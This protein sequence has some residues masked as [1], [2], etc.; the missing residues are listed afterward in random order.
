MA[1]V[2]KA[3]NSKEDIHQT[4]IIGGFGKKGL[5]NGI[6]T[7]DTTWI[8]DHDTK[9]YDQDWPDMNNYRAGFGCATFYSNGHKGRPILIAAGSQ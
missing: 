3:K 2:L 4:F 8:F 5:F 7:R 6:D 1:P 9:T